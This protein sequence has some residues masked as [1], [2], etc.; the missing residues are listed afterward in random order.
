MSKFNLSTLLNKASLGSETNEGHKLKVEYLS[1]HDLIPSEENFY[2]VEDIEELKNSI[3]MFGVKQNLTVLNLDN[4][5]YK[6]IAG[7]RRRLASL[8]LVQEGKTEFEMVPCAVESALDHI[9]EQL[10]LITTNATARQ[11]TDY[12]KVLQAEKIKVLLEDYKKSEKVTGRI[13][14]L[15]AQ[16]LDTSSA[17]VGRM[18]SISKNLDVGFKE[19]FKAQEINVSTA[20]ELSTLPQGEQE[21]VLKTFEEGGSLSIKDVRE[22]KK[23]L[24][25]GDESIPQ[26]KGQMGITEFPQCLPSE[27]QEVVD[28]SA[29][30]NKY[31]ERKFIV[32]VL[33]EDLDEKFK[34]DLEGYIRGAIGDLLGFDADIGFRVE[35]V[36]E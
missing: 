31:T 23:S 26:A 5:K 36:E 32:T 27:F 17:Q 2:S 11:L 13:R 10:L 29:E 22:K 8:A 24:A 19:A 15:I 7:H 35:E 12:E 18:E 1:V 6:I 21:R 20:Y 4:G 3:E 28:V 9:R 33:E 30:D 34:D 25:A 16:I 14:D